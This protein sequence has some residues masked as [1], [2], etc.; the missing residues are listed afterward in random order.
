VL[1]STIAACFAFAVKQRSSRQPGHKKMT[2]TISGGL[3][4][5]STSRLADPLQHLQVVSFCRIAAVPGLSSGKQEIDAPNHA[6]A[7]RRGA[8][9]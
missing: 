4:E 9:C 2:P 8:A 7:E 1:L 3:R 6:P 5:S